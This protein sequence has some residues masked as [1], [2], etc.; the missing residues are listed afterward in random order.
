MEVV[1][2]LEQKHHHGTR[3]LTASHF[4][5]SGSAIKMSI[6]GDTVGFNKSR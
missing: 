4:S 2:R 1:S 6:E 5:N 3:Q